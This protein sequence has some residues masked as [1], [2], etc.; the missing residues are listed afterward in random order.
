MSDFSE[1][2]KEDMFPFIDCS[3]EDYVEP[4]KEPVLD[5]DENFI[6]K[7]E[8]ENRQK[9]KRLKDGI[10]V[11]AIKIDNYQSN[12]ERFY[13]AQPFFY[14]TNGLFWFW[15]IK[16]DCWQIVDDIDIMNAIEERYNFQ[17]LTVASSIKHNYLEAFKR[18]G[19]R[20]RPKD[21]PNKWIQFKNKAY[22]L[23][24]KVQY[25]VTPDYFFT[26]PIPYEI[27][28]S[29][30]TPIMDKL[31]EEWVGKEY[32]KTMYEIIAYCCY[33]SYPIQLLFC[34][35]GSGRNGKSCFLRLLNK[36]LGYYNV[37]STELDT[38]M[39]SRF[40]A[41][42]LYKKLAC[43][44]GETNFGTI[45]KTSML[46]KLVGGDIIAFEKKNKDPFDDFNYA[47][48]M[49][50]SNSLPS[51]DDTSE[52]FYRRWMIIDFPNEFPEGKD[53]LLSIPEQEYSNLAR[54]VTEILPILIEKGTFT[55]QGDIFQRKH[56]YEMASN[57]LP[58]FINNCCIVDKEDSETFISYNKLYTA[59]VGFLKHFKKRRVKT[60][61]FKASLENE[62][63]W[64]EKT[65]KK[66]DDGAWKSGNWIV[67]LTLKIDYDKYSNYE[68]ISTP[69]PYTREGDRKQSIK[70]I[71][72]TKVE[73]EQV[74]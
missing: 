26:N 43:F 30:E 29:N 10:R 9:I 24:A 28:N 40:E 65:S 70:G 15:S 72:N 20:K 38:L 34:L 4:L 1:D 2:E 16:E 59:Y 12:I 52:G 36:F 44:M 45:R 66:V 13:D 46:K 7:L 71:I 17:G 60:T 14:D 35:Y 74:E 37:C 53:I 68:T 41:F 51:T 62:G 8:W 5:E 27:G 33:S 32:V 19:R 23:S 47:K 61:E 56:K 18:V 3:K 58:I 11:A 49:I 55:N 25:T 6:E 69:F 50:A 57:P 22:S 64:I 39:D 67:G 21:A 73:E 42:K 48:I 63:F 54:K 31:F